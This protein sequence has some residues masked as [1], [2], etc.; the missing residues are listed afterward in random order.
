MTSG[1]DPFFVWRI[2]ALLLVA[3]VPSHANVSAEKIVRLQNGVVLRGDVLN[4]MALGEGSAASESTSLPLVVVDDGLRRVYVSKRG[5]VA[6]G[7]LGTAPDIVRR[8]EL[9]QLE[10]RQGKEVL[11]VGPIL[12]ATNFDAYGRRKIQVRGTTGA[13]VTFVQGITEINARYLKVKN[14]DAGSQAPWEMRISSDRFHEATLLAIFRQLIDKNDL[15]NRSLAVS[16]LIEM[17]RYAAATSMLEEILEDFPN[18]Q[19]HANLLGSIVS[20][21]GKQ[22]L[23]QTA[24]M[25][26][27][28]QLKKAEEIL[29]QYPLAQVDGETRVEV[30]DALAEIKAIRANRDRIVDLLRAE[31]SSLKPGTADA[32][33]RLVTEIQNNWSDTT[34]PRMVDFDQLSKVDS[35]TSEDRVAL[36][37]SG[38]LLGPGNGIRNLPVA[39]SLIEVRTLVREYLD[40]DTAGRRAEI[41]RLLRQIEG[42][43]PQYV[44]KMLPMLPAHYSVRDDGGLPLTS[45]VPMTAN[46]LSESLDDPIDLTQPDANVIPGLHLCQAENSSSIDTDYLIQLPP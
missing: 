10:Q 2:A 7:P 18:Q 42:A 17:E 11:G 29:R 44:S 33:I 26:S 38:W 23:D 41:L 22:L 31:I 5:M 45:R 30:Q 25:R 24:V 4:V 14:L 3:A 34:A 37:V 8:F 40:C 35:I 16:I 27:A 12:N 43:Q 1:A 46:A 6:D 32:A 20:R 28:G 15:E 39:L 19:Q 36:A 9:W 21:Q 13:P